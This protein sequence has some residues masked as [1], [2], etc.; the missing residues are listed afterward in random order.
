MAQKKLKDKI[1]A[2]KDPTNE[3]NSDKYHTG[4][5]CIECGVKPAG[6]AWGLYWCFECN[7][8]RMERISSQLEQLS[9]VNKK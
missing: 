4:E 1:E 5:Y 3:G 6:T 2:Y 7:V 9:K 8:K